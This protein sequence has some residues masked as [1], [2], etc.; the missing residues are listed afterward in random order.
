MG[1]W[2][3]NGRAPPWKQ[4]TQCT[5]LSGHLRT[6]SLNGM[7]VCTTS[8]GVWIHVPRTAK[9][10]EEKQSFWKVHFQ[11]LHKAVES[12]NTTVPLPRMAEM[13]GH[14]GFSMS[15]RAFTQ[16]GSSAGAKFAGQGLVC[17]VCFCW[18]NGDEKLWIVLSRASNASNFC[19]SAPR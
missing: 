15:L 9:M 14:L 19:P 17:V 7:A 11:N 12:V 6:R 13:A 1:S 2:T 4:N 5:Q 10:V 16:L 8:A 18:C 3:D